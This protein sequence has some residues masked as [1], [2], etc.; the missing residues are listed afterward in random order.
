[1][2]GAVRPPAAPARPTGRAPRD[3]CSVRSSRAAA[4]RYPPG[5]FGRLFWVRHR[6]LDQR[7]VAHGSPHYG[8]YTPG[9]DPRAGSILAVRVSTRGDY[10]SRALLSLALHGAETSDVGSGHRGAHG[11]APALPRTDPPRPQGGRPGP[12]KPGV[13]GGYVL[14]AHPRSTPSLRSS[15]RWTGR[16][17]PATSGSRT[18]TAPA[19]TRASACCWRCGRTWARPIRTHLQSYSL[20]DM[21]DRAAATSLRPLSRVRG[22]SGPARAPV[23]LLDGRPFVVPSQDAVPPGRS[24]KRRPATGEAQA[25]G[26]PARGGGA[27]GR[28]TGSPHRRP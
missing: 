21:V 25:N 3:E 26:P 16:S 15:L 17:P 28:R 27:R 23:P 11:P 9:T 13:G 7:S 12:S 6:R 20:A 24:R 22:P 10:A 2:A 14:A 5:I 18:R 1:M 19:T 4:V 8:P